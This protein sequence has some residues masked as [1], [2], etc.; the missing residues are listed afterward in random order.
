VSEWWCRK[1]WE[2]DFQADGFSLFLLVLSVVVREKTY[3]NKLSGSGIE[4]RQKSK[5][6]TNSLIN[7]FIIIEYT[8]CVRASNYPTKSNLARNHE[9]FFNRNFSLLATWSI[10]DPFWR[11]FSSFSQINKNPFLHPKKNIMKSQQA[12]DRTPLSAIK[13]LNV[14]WK[15]WF[16]ALI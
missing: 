9:V 7:D 8:C 2:T 10:V 3:K 13:S 11:L 14:Y 12:N 1:G 5:K 16:R 15:V 4:L 6:R